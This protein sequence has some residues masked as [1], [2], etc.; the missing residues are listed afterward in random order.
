MIS[1]REYLVNLGILAFFLV[2]M[3]FA[4]RFPKAAAAYPILICRVG[5]VLT[6]VLSVKMLIR[7]AKIRKS[8]Q[9]LE[10]TR[11]QN[12]QKTLTKEHYKNIGIFMGMLLLYILSIRGL[13][14]FV[15]TI[16]Y[17]I[18]SMSIFK[19]RF[20]W[21]IVVI[22]IVFTI[23]MYLTFDQFLHIV[24]PHGIFY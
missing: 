9:D 24:I 1:K 18:V 15:S 21:V 10:E 2:A 6:L 13:G 3:M 22:A 4:S 14:Y 7:D 16:T 8:E 23:V 17:L 20:S 11:E 12:R 19:K 5:I